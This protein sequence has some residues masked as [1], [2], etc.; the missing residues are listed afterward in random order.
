MKAYMSDV[1]GGP[2]FYDGD[3]A[4]ADGS[5]FD[6]SGPRDDVTV[7][8]A[9]MREA[10]R[11]LAETE[12]SDGPWDGTEHVNMYGC[13]V[14]GSRQHGG[15]VCDSDYG[16]CLYDCGCHAERAAL[17]ESLAAFIAMEVE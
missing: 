7:E 12:P 9:A 15:M 4:Y 11:I 17:A 2:A 1:G 6:N 16:G 10:R 8:E 13:G 14:C 3:M 5:T